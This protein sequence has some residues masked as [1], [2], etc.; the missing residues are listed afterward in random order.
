MGK[1]NDI[2]KAIRNI[3]NW[4][5]R[6]EWSIEISTVF[7]AHLAPVCEL[8]DISP[9]ELQQKIVELDY[10]G[11]VFGVMF[12][13]LLSRRLS[14]ADKNI[15]DDYLTR[16]GWRESVSGRRYLQQIRDSVLSL[17]EVAEVS[18]GKYCDLSDLVRGG[19][20][21]RVY[22][23]MGTQ[24]LVKWDRIAARVLTTNGKHI[25]SG[26]ILPFPR[27]ASQD[28][29][30]VLTKSRKQFRRR[31]S[32]SVDKSSKADVP[33]SEDEDLFLKDACPAF[34]SIWLVHILEQLE[35]PLPEMVNRNGAPLVYS[36]TRF[37]VLIENTETIAER[38]DAAAGWE[39]VSPEEDVWIWLRE[40]SAYDKK[41]GRGIAIDA[42]LDGQHPIDGTLRLNPDVLTLVTNSV[43]R[44]E[45]GTDDLQALLGDAI[46]PAMSLLQ[47]PDQLMADQDRH[48]GGGKRERPIDI[49]PRIEAEI[50]QKTL[51]QHYRQCLDE[52]IPA[53][54][55]KTPRQCSR[56]KQGRKKLVEWL[57]HLES[58]ELRRAAQAGQEPYDSSWMWDELKLPS[59]LD[60]SK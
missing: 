20:T 22:E 12:E 60:V 58:N 30:D 56:S 11:M 3:K 26:G 42:S 5:D 25:F 27:D 45:R 2:D 38:L 10:G 17:Y 34:T 41:A 16:R 49:D 1:R 44:A 6:P 8:V 37:P 28:L 33:L 40:S 36:E 7:D 51:D 18:R 39:R 53:L 21:I 15:I 55:N 57:K 50:V 43:D 46:G 14:P 13:D 19:K 32:R 24:N 48:H 35:A 23:H 31:R 59:R 52:T 54:D 4:A 29:L 9:D 47:T